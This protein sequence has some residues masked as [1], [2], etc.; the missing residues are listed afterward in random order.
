MSTEWPRAAVT[1]S[2]SN[3]NGCDGDTLDKFK[4]MDVP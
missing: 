4:P 2:G 3:A 1:N